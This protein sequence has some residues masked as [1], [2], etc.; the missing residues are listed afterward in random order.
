MA[1]KHSCLKRVLLVSA[2]IMAFGCGGSR[3]LGVTREVPL[4]RS[5]TVIGPTGGSALVG[6]AGAE[7]DLAPGSL[8]KSS[9]VLLELLPP[10]SNPYPTLSQ[11]TNLIRIQIEPSSLNE[12]DTPI[13][14]ALPTDEQPHSG[15]WQ[16]GVLVAKDEL[17]VPA[18]ASFSILEGTS[19]VRFTISAKHLR[20]A[21]S[22]S[23]SGTYFQFASI[24]SVGDQQSLVEW[25]DYCNMYELLSVQGLGSHWVFADPSLVPDSGTPRYAFVLHGMQNDV[26]RMTPLASYLKQL[27]SLGGANSTYYSR[28]FGID[29][30]WKDS[31]KVNGNRFAAIITTL[32]E[33]V[34]GCTIDVFGH[35]MGG[36][37]A[38]WAIEKSEPSSG[39]GSGL[40]VDRLFT[41]GTPHTGVPIKIAQLAM[42]LNFQGVADL[43][44]NG[45]FITDLNQSSP[46]FRPRSYISFRGDNHDYFG[47]LG[48]LVHRFYESY[49]QSYPDA[50]PCDGIVDRSS[51]QPGLL[52][53]RAL[54]VYLPI[55]QH[56][57]HT[58]MGGQLS[59]DSLNLNTGP[60]AGQIRSFILEIGEGGIDIR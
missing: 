33:S 53:S 41:L 29:Y 20:R 26:N 8:S 58:D 18:E 51:S 54:S 19:K 57:N 44:R 14:I 4:A 50:L 1:S 24:P 48:K 36:L 23:P 43:T 55:P 15:F 39:G 35:S 7:V 38:R 22:Y 37:V 46:A 34:P 21:L 6:T 5:T 56:Y 30:Q 27:R 11:R 52:Y 31:I 13:S 42:I 47:F 3:F 60:F 40:Q 9:A 59:G 16:F 32:R 10:K 45:P 28:V 2:L 25:D 49:A 12:S 17:I